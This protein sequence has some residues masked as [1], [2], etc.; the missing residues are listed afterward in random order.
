MEGRFTRWQ[1][2]TIAQLGYSINLVL[3]F[4]V[5]SLGF[6]LS[7]ARSTT[8]LASNCWAKHLLLVSV[9][10]ILLSTGAG[11]WCVIN[12]LRDFRKTESIARGKERGELP[13]CE[14]ALRK[15]ETVKLGKRTWLLFWWQIGL[16]SF[17]ILAL[18]AGFL[19]LYHGNL[20]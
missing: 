6:T 3:T 9:V 17:G 13:P 15:A 7:L 10:L 4:S 16:F 20:V 11:L 8:Q 2:I 19:T 18:V 1:S 5:A 14:Y 12:R